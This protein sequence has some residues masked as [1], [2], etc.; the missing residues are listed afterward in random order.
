LGQSESDIMPEVDSGISNISG[1]YHVDF[2][3]VG[4]AGVTFISG[5]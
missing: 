2:V 3:V 5:L 1:G 4:V